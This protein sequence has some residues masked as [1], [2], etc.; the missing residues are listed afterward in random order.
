MGTWPINIEPPS[1]YAWDKKRMFKE[2]FL[3]YD[4]ANDRY[5]IMAIDK[6]DE[7][8]FKEAIKNISEQIEKY[9]RGEIPGKE[10]LENSSL[11]EIK[12][13]SDI[14]KVLATYENIDGAC[15]SAIKAEL[16]SQIINSLLVGGV[17]DPNDC[18][19]S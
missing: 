10:L 18:K 17:L 4:G 6:P 15:R 16:C 2:H 13:K 9:E 12:D 8:Q 1:E 14:E 3:Y 19:K 5:Y 7:Y 11:K